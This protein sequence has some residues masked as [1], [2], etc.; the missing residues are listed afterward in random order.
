MIGIV[1]VTHGNLAQEFKLALEH[2]VGP[3][4]NMEAINIAAD[5]DMELRGK[6][7]SD[8]LTQVETG[9]GVIILT[10]LFG[11]TPSNIAIS[12]M[13]NDK[14]EVIAGINLPMLIKLAGLRESKTIL[15]AAELAQEAGRKYIHVASKVLQGNE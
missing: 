4:D 15:E 10:D 9:S 3:Q 13:Q 6:D 5:D 14:V 12:M 1:I 7:I 11:G 2:I 8:M